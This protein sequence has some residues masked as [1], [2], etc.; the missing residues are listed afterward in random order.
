MTNDVTLCGGNHLDMLCVISGG[1]PGNAS[2]A[3]VGA[4]NLNNNRTNS[5]TNVGVFADS[6]PSPDTQQC[7]TGFEGDGFQLLAAKSC[8]RP[9]FGSASENWRI[10]L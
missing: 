9:P 5:N 4:R 3:G 8:V 7:D 10:G 1:N 6:S 2:N